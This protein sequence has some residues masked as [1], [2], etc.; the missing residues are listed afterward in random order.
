MYFAGLVY[1]PL[2]TERQIE[3]RWAK[4]ILLRWSKYNHMDLLKSL[5]K[6]NSSH[7]S[8]CHLPCNANWRR[9][10]IVTFLLCHR[11]QSFDRRALIGSVLQANRR[12]RTR[13]TSQARFY[14]Q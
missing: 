3:R 10:E 8:V 13:Q 4:N 6:T 2:L 14:Y 9:Y 11:W 7:F 12:R 5:W 1:I